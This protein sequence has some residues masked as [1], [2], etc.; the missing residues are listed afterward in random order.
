MSFWLDVLRVLE[1]RKLKV[2]QFTAR[3]QFFVYSKINLDLS[4]ED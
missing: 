3:K 4:V 2:Q 1:S